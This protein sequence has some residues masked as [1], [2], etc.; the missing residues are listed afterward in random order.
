MRAFVTG[1]T[2][3]IGSHLVKKLLD[4]GVS[5]AA[6]IRPKSNT[7]RLKPVL[8]KIEIIKGDLHDVE[9]SFEKIKEFSPEVI[10]HLA[11][12]GA[13]SYEYENHDLQVFH[14]VNG[15]LNLIKIAN[16]IGCKQ[17]IGLGSV[18]EYGHCNVP[19]TESDYAKPNN[20]YGR[21]KLSVCLL[22]EKLCEGY[23]IQ[24]SWIRM[25]WAYGPYDD[26]KR[27]IPYF[28]KTLLDGKKPFTTLGKQK[29]DYLYIDDVV[30]ALW[31]VTRGKKINGIYNLG[32]GQSFTLRSTLE[33]IR[34]IINPNLE[35]G[36]GEIPYRPDQ[37]MHLKADISLLKKTIGWEPEISLSEGMER[38]VNWYRK[39]FY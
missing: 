5:V 15:S 17:W 35:I 12:S 9:A 23:N 14:N 7:W 30:N 24:F 4:E 37:I 31:K 1:A 8:S 39:E 25:F 34:D 32:S 16:N 21:S 29:W 22:A 38:T 28:I 36:F 10:F 6:F 11:W 13:N 20:L 19:V 2:G 27:L 26:E 33:H 3:F 18:L